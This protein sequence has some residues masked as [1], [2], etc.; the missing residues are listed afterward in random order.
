[1]L[2]FLILVLI[3]PGWSAMLVGPATGGWSNQ[4]RW[5]TQFNWWQILDGD[6]FFFNFSFN[7]NFNLEL[8]VEMSKGKKRAQQTLNPF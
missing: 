3:R 5:T 8:N 1:M 7:F 2:S 4:L 6:A